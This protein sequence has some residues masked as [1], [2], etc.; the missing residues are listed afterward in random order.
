MN[1][2]EARSAILRSELAELAPGA[3]GGL[4]QHIERCEQCRAYARMIIGRTGMLRSAVVAR[5]PSVPRRRTSRRRV[6][7]ALTVA[8]GLVAA[9]ALARRTLDAPTRI[10]SEH[11]HGSAPVTIENA[12]GR[13]VTIVEHRDTINII[14]H[15]TESR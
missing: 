1:C 6:I 7:G 3:T 4:A 2:S 12:Q 9:V 14:F 10:I 8:A 11:G 5:G 15:A 13:A